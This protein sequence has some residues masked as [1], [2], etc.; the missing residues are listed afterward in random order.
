VR[1]VLRVSADDVPIGVD[2][3]EGEPLVVLDGPVRPDLLRL[4]QGVPAVIVGVDV[5]AEDP[6]TVE[7]VERAVQAHSDAAI[8]LAVLLRGSDQRS[9]GEGLV[10]ESSTYSLLQGGADHHRWLADRP[11][12]PQAPGQ[13]DGGDVVEVRRDGDVLH[14]VLSRPE[15][16]NA[17]SAAVRDA[18]IDALTIAAADPSLRVE[19]RGRGPSF[20]SGGDLS[21]FGTGPDPA[22]AHVV[23]LR[24]N[25]GRAIADVAD[26]ATAYVHGA[27]VGAGVELPAFAGRVVAAPDARFWL[28]ELS[29]G[30]I[31]GA[32]GTVSLPGR[33]GRQRTA[34]LALTG[35]PIDAM[36][37]LAWGLVDEV[38]PDKDHDES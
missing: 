1:H 31:P 34:V 15:V 2:P 7:A 27:C 29:M 13:P 5:P 32:G 38:L 9:I 8:A 6:A 4:L 33:I 11:E 10:A 20:C 23:R 22:S 16:R 19:L 26:R 3:F 18:L 30:L 28:P 21:E 14:V 17:F 37:A 25:A 12:Q 36:T 35:R 24:R